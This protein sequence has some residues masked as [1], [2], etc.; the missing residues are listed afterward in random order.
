MT[1]LPG[2]ARTVPVL[3]LTLFSSLLLLAIGMGARAESH[4]GHHRG[5]ETIDPPKGPGWRTIAI[6]SARSGDRWGGAVSAG[7]QVWTPPQRTR[8]KITTR[9]KKLDVYGGIAVYAYNTDYF[10]VCANEPGGQQYTREGFLRRPSGGG[11]RPV[12][13]PF[14]KRMKMPAKASSPYLCRYWAGAVLGSRSDGRIR[15]RIQVKR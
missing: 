1:A 7:I 5:I 2:K 12:Q 4:D 8:V 10:I 14:T 6:D 9:P 11:L 15:L 13:T 3:A